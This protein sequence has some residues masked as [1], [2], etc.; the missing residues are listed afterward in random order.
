MT[1]P[2]PDLPASH[3]AN[4]LD[5]RLLRVNDSDFA[6]KLSFG[7][8]CSIAA[9][10]L[11]GINPTQVALAYGINRRTCIRIVEQG[12]KYRAVKDEILRLGQATFI[13]TYVTESAMALINAHADAP[14]LKVKVTELPKKGERGNVPNKRASANAGISVYKPVAAPHSHRID[15]QWGKFHDDT[16]EGWWSQLLDQDDMLGQWFGDPEKGTH[17]TSQSALRHAKTF[18]DETY[19]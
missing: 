11:A 1:L 15:V 10:Q 16:P 5:P 8:R 14:E 4:K 19:A 17:V 18:L 6:P 9:L 7:E 3:P 12:S 13:S 2:F